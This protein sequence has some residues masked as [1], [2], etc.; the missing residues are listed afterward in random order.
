MAR[1]NE[2]RIDVEGLLFWFGTIYA[3]A[4]CHTCGVNGLLLFWAERVVHGG[5]LHTNK[6]TAAQDT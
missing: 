6:R 2:T 1:K 4:C 5:L 3:C